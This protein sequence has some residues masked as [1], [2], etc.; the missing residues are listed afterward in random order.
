MSHVAM[1][2]LALHDAIRKELPFSAFCAH[3]L[4]YRAMSG[5]GHVTVGIAHISVGE[6]SS[7]VNAELEKVKVAQAEILGAIGDDATKIKDF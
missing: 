3:F 2:A 6:A 1:V 5:V 4:R 7:E